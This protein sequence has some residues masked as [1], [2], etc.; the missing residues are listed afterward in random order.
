MGIACSGGILT[1]VSGGNKGTSVSFYGVRG[2]TPCDGARYRRYGGNTSCVV[3]ESAARDG[4]GPIVLDLGTGLRAFGEHL[5]TTGRGFGLRA[6]ALLTHLHW[7][8]VQGL[9]FF[10]PLHSCESS[11]DVYGPRQDAGSLREVFTGLMRPPYFP[12]R[13][14]GLLGA[15][16][17]HDAGDDDFPVGD[18]K[19]RSRWVRH[20]DPTLGFRLDWHG[21]SIAYIS[22]HGPGCSPDDADDFVPVDVLDL[23]D[24]V[25]L[26]VHDAQHSCEEYE[27]KRHYGHSTVDYAVYVAREAGARN[28]ALFHHCPTHSD[29]DVDRLLAYAR[30]LAARIGG[31]EVL[32]AHEGLC[33]DL[34]SGGSP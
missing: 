4:E 15:V 27:T 3:V 2:S 25:D 1:G 31:P 30:D 29:D 6:S 28:L 17:F 21:T 11:V 34:V 7:D 18:A 22:D 26:L 19:V 32:A 16:S 14:E 8:H 12:I 5:M 23:A 13:P 20:T 9:P 10:T 24:G 33:V